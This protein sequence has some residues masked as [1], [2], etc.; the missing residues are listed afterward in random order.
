MRKF[1]SGKYLKGRR[2]PDISNRIRTFKNVFIENFL[3]SLAMGCFSFDR[4]QKPPKIEIVDKIPPG[5]EFDYLRL[6]NK[7]IY[8]IDTVYDV[9]RIEIA[10]DEWYVNS[11]CF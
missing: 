4:Q 9:P 8:S 2:K 11:V 10:F 1:L 7:I 6:E 3:F 5:Q